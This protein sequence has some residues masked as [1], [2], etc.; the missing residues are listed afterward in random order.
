MELLTTRRLELAP[1]DAARDLG[2]LHAMFADPE[3]ARAGYSAPSRGE[4][5]SL[6]R[7]Q[8]EFGD[9]GGWTWVLRIRPD[10]TAVGVIGVFSDQ[11][12]PIRGMSW[13]LQRDHWG[14]GLMSEAARTV[15]DYLL[16]QPSIAG[17]EAW[18]DSRNTRSIGVARHA[19]LDLV[20]RLPRSDKGEIAQSVVM[21]RAAHPSD[22]TTFAVRPVLHVRDVAATVT[23]LSDLLGLHTHF[24]FGEPEPE[25][26]SLG[27]TPWNGGSGLDV[28]RATAE[29]APTTI[30]F[31][32]GVLVDP[33]YDA[34]VSAGLVDST[35]PT[36]TPWHRRTFTLILA[37]GHH[38]TLSGPPISDPNRL[39]SM[40]LIE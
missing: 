28:Q 9:N 1:Y 11:G 32:V 36:D 16:S 40:G 15:V 22:P 7:L 6:D 34:A 24:Q 33:L 31:D 10:E 3:W 17:V 5:E 8:R 13:Y 35:P 21:A 25:F 37:E 4:D 29:I 27:F 30:T 12:T 18:I 38:L 2:A 20:G 23:L 26:A 14:S 19:G 39:P